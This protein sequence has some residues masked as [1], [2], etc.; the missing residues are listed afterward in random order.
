MTTTGTGW[1]TT[2]PAIT[3]TDC[4]QLPK[5]AAA[6][7]F[8]T[9]PSCNFTPM[10]QQNPPALCSNAG[11]SPQNWLFQDFESGLGAWTTQQT[12]VNPAT[13]QDRPWTVK[14]GAPDGHPGQVVFGPDPVV[15]DCANDLENGVTSLLSP[16]VTIPANATTSRQKCR[17]RSRS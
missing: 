15:G 11:D 6:V 7:S 14:S 8:R 9:P 3:Q 13:W 1:G 17:T 5:V 16:V 4:D 10:F 12:P 2:T